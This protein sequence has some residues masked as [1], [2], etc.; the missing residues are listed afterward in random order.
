ML[1]T[2]I[3]FSVIEFVILTSVQFLTFRL[4]AAR[5]GVGQLG[6]W[7]V[8]IASVQ[9]AKMLDPGLT[10]GSV[11]FIVK[12]RDLDD[13]AAI[14]RLISTTVLVTTAT[15]GFALLLAYYPLQK[16][17]A[18]AI[19]QD[20]LQA[21]LLLPYASMS[22]YSQSVAGALLNSLINVGVSQV[23]SV[24]SSIGMLL[25]FTICILLID[26]HGLIGVAVA[27][28]CN[29]A[30][31]AVLS[32]FYLIAFARIPFRFLFLPTFRYLGSM[33]QTG[34]T[35]QASSLV[36]TAFELLSRVLMS[37][38]GGIEMVGYSEVATRAA[39]Q[40]RLL[41]Y[42]ANQSIVPEYSSKQS[43]GGLKEF[44][45]TVYNN[46]ALIGFVL[47]LGLVLI[48]PFIY[49]LLFNQFNLVFFAII[50]LAT[51]GGYLNIL[52]MPSESLGAALALPRGTLIGAVLRL[53]T[54]CFVIVLFVGEVNAI[55]VASA[56]CFSIALGACATIYLNS[57]KLGLRLFP[58]RPQFTVLYR[59]IVRDLKMT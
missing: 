20:A 25:Q 18:F 4:V 8:L 42:Y 41:M 56:V 34:A 16:L 10:A 19:P 47:S 39:A 46:F 14:G 15:I 37:R 40:M 51:M 32:I 31:L 7:S 13:R 6:I 33:T 44:Y 24:I 58:E 49:V 2:K 1:R 17:V 45:I 55:G 22:Y 52:S 3:L 21:N 48:L 11:R 59:L 36:V 26:G 57:L 27:Q 28:M 30:V 9:V 29:Y 54:L 35:L 38:F 53:I 23:K 5:L 12:A 50:I 43:N